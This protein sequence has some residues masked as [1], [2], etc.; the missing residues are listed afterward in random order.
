[1]NK[2]A[3]TMMNLMTL[4]SM[5]I[6]I[7]LIPVSGMMYMIILMTMTI[8]DDHDHDQGDSDDDH[9]DHDHYHGDYECVQGGLGSVPRLF[10]SKRRSG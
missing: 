2:S 9:D 1:M 7:G 4:R 8:P 6:M 10:G 5:I 3:M